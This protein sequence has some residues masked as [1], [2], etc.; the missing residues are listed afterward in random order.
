[1]MNEDIMNKEYRE[2]LKKCALE[3]LNRLDKV[4]DVDYL[5]A[6]GTYQFADDMLGMMSKLIETDEWD[7][8]R[9]D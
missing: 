6:N 5:M 1:M 7:S 4:V 8:K 9:F 3:V 2:E